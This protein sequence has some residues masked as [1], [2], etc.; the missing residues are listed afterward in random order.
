M[1]LGLVSLWADTKQ[2]A[3][4]WRDPPTWNEIF[5]T[6]LNVLKINS[7]FML[8]HKWVINEKNSA[9]RLTNHM[10]ENCCRE[11]DGRSTGRS[12]FTPPI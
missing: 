7:Y 11:N 5:R 6:M 12:N 9:N 4:T 2:L 1:I 10:Q 3:A 8:S